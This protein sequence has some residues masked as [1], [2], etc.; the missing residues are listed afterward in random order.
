MQ[1]LRTAIVRNENH[2]GHAGTQPPLATQRRIVAELETERK[3][4]EANREL[5]VR[6]EKKMWA[7]LAEMWGEEGTREDTPSER[8]KL[9]D[10]SPSR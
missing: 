9:A 10:S 7:K 5:I 1:N 3:L 6:M 2:Q 4:A 8:T